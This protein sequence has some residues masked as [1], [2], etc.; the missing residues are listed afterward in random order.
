MRVKAA[1]AKAWTLLKTTVSEWSD[2]NAAR[3]AAALAFYTLLSL[4]PLVILIIALVGVVLGEAKAR[5]QIIQEVGSMVGPDGVRA[6]DA[7]VASA[8][9]ATQGIV[10]S[11]I[12]LIVLFVG[13]SGVFGELQYALNTIWGVK[14]RPRNGLMLLIRERIFSFAMVIA[15]A[16]LLLVSL[17][18]SAVLAALGR[19]MADALPGGATLWQIVN[20]FASIGVITLLFALIFRV[21]PDVDIE[22][23]PVW[24][25]ALVTAVLFTIGKQLLGVYL[26]KSSVASAYGAAGSIVALV[27]WVYYSSQL[28]FF[29]AE[30]TQVYAR[31]S[32]GEIRPSRNAVFM[33]AD[34]ASKTSLPA[35]RGAT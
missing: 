24:I 6:I 27:V 11:F 7:V 34:H 20:T 32:G 4:A 23:R 21:V 28:V 12:G 10:G 14:P 30:F 22:W 8:S 33:D 13:A 1:A 5:A 19:F 31:M 17:V 2:D 16:F 35:E 15:V 29:G 25:G 18:V 9:D 3:V 26:G